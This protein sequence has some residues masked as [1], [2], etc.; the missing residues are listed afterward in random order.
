MKKSGILI[1]LSG[2][3]G[4]GK[5]TLVRRVRSEL[6]E[7]EFSVSCTTRA[8]RA[9]ERNGVDYNFLSEAEF[10]SRSRNG[11]FLE[12]AKVF[13][14]R[15]G[16]LRSEVDAR[17]AAGKT[18]LLDID[19]QGARQIR[20]ATAADPGLAARTA[21][22]MIVPPS[23]ETLETRLR[24]RSSDSEEQISL[25]LAGAKREL[26]A[27]RLYDFIVVNDDVDEAAAELTAIFRALRQRTALIEGESLYE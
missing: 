22:V 8:P 3:S 4:V 15:Y 13:N 1:V 16:T 7:V 6:G 26:D 25:R 20:A 10:E 27:F 19:V 9:G 12:E 14:H 23:L 11:E 17:I 24:G 18:V 21:L 2:P 5:S